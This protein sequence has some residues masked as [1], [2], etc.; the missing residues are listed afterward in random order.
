MQYL[1]TQEEPDALKNAP[2]VTKQEAFTEVLSALCG[3]LSSVTIRKDLY[4]HQSFVMLSDMK[5]ALER[6]KARFN[7]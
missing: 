6:T 7:N 4:S 5:A 3:E 1:L 2:K